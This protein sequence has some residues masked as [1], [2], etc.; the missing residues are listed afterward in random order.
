MTDETAELRRQLKEAHM[1]R[2][3]VYAAFHDELVARFGADVAEE[4]MKAAIYKRG[5]EIGR[6]SCRERV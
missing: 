6:A 2:A 4:V 5:L 3:M 1:S